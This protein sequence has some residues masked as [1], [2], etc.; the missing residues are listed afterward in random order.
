[1][2]SF[3]KDLYSFTWREKHV[4][5]LYRTPNEAKLHRTQNEASGAV[6]VP[7]KERLDLCNIEDGDS[8]RVENHHCPTKN[9]NGI[10]RGSD[11]EGQEEE[12]PMGHSL[13]KETMRKL[14]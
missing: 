6:N 7:K 12:K 9:P 10:L 5:K 11:N 13:E 1:M 8:H 14:V 4:S 2:S 3:H